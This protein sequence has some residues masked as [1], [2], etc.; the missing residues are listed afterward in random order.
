MQ[1]FSFLLTIVLFGLMLLIGACGGSDDNGDNGDITE[2]PDINPENF[3]WD[4]YIV[5]VAGMLREDYYWINA[6]WL[7]SNTAIS[8]TDVISIQFD[9]ADPVTLQQTGY[10]GD[11]FFTGEAQLTPGQSY[12]VKLF[13]NGD[14]EAA[15]TLRMPYRSFATFPAF[16]NPSSA[17]SL[18]WSL[19]HDN[20]FQVA[21]VS[22]YDEDAF[23]S[24]DYMDF[25]DPSARSLS[26]PANAVQNYGEYTTYEMLVMQ[27]SFAKQGRNAFSAAQG[28][29]RTYPDEP[30]KNVK[31]R[32]LSYMQKARRSM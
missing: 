31:N 12:R 26:I 28:S 20:Q 10:F 23:E 6:D 5:D 11:P 14:Q 4:V 9:N 30:V 27:Y 3:D 29:G 32:M 16:Y 19:E 25:V 17:T 8:D 1:R 15:V 2:I 21:G 24:D 13:K 7:G 18:N 22:S